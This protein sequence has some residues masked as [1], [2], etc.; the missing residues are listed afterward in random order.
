MEGHQ[1]SVGIAFTFANKLSEEGGVGGFYSLSCT[2]RRLN[3]IRSD[4]YNTPVKRG[5]RS[6]VSNSVVPAS[7]D[8]RSGHIRT[9]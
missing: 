3:F 6:G 4:K 8:A 9:S 5:L 7:A 2:Q 1:S